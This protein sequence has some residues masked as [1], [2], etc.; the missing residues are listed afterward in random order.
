MDEDQYLKDLFS[1]RL[2]LCHKKETPAQFSL[3]DPRRER[4][5]VANHVR[6]TVTVDA[7]ALI[8]RRLHPVATSVA[9]L[10]RE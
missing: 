2:F 8:V 9:R 7:N 3:R 10:Q 5:V 4:S 1:S 6:V